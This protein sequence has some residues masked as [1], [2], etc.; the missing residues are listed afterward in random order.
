MP[1]PLASTLQ[2]ENKRDQN[3]FGAHFHQLHAK[4]TH[5]DLLFEK[6][7]EYYLLS[8]LL[9]P[10]QEGH[11]IVAVSREGLIQTLAKAVTPSQHMISH[12]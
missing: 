5:Q 3:F 8:S 12:G 2:H 6:L 1:L 9:L 11:N 10:R 7:L 4:T